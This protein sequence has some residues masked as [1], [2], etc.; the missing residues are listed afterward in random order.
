MKQII[1]V[2]LCVVIPSVGLAATESGYKVRY[3]GGSIQS[4]KSG[5]DVH[6]LLEQKQIR[7]VKNKKDVAVV[8]ASAITEVSYG[9]GVHRRVGAAIGIGVVT[10]GLG[11][12]MA[13]AKSKK[14]FI[15]LTWDDA[16]NKGGFAF[17]ADKH[18]YRG[19]MA[20]LEGLSGKKAV[21]ADAMTV[22]N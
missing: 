11:A 5:D 22:K 3:D 18:E 15:G 14:H 13:L 17:Q 8:P 2:L 21:N 10:F 9:Q 20:G 4:L 7:L 16:G 12:L 6:V 19:I 1:A